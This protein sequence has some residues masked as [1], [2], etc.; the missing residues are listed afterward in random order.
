MNKHS[1]TDLSE[2][3]IIPSD[4]GRGPYSWYDRTFSKMDKDSL[5]G[6]IFVLIVSALGTGLLTTHHLFD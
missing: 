4:I 3:L 6:G 5:R 2:E 1:I